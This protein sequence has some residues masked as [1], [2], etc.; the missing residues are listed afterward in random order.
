MGVR[1]GEGQRRFS[2]SLYPCPSETFSAEGDHEGSQN[3]QPGFLSITLLKVRRLK[4]QEPA[5]FGVE[6]I[7]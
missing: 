1:K 3:S 7:E 2:L 4:S 6:F 5:E